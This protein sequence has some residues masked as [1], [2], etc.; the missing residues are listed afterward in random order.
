MH[1]IKLD[2][3]IRADWTFTF[4]GNPPEAV[5]AKQNYLAKNARKDGFG[6][7]HRLW[8]NIGTGY[9]AGSGLPMFGVDTLT[10]DQQSV[11]IVEA[12]SSMHALASASQVY[13]RTVAKG[14]RC[15]TGEE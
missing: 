8:Y 15:T 10:L 13:Y 6:D 9:W 4:R 11:L 2:S 14:K 7:Y 5:I 1:Y 3:A 12:Q